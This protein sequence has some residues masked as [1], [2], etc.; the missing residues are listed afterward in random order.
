MGDNAEEKSFA[1]SREFLFRLGGIMPT[2][3]KGWVSFHP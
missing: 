2:R 1:A 3:I